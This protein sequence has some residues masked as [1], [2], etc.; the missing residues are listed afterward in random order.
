M[1]AKL[2]T[3]NVYGGPGLCVEL[4]FCQSLTNSVMRIWDKVFKKQTISFQRCLPQILLG[5]FLNTLTHI[6][7]TLDIEMD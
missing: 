2:T 3:L 4:G 5:P 7:L 1:V 6:I